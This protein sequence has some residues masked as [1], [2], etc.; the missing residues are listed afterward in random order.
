MLVRRL[1]EV[2][3]ENY[4]QLLNHFPLHQA[5]QGSTE[6]VE[7]LNTILPASSSE[8]VTSTEILQYLRKGGQK[9]LNRGLRLQR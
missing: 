4:L 1:L 9:G 8:C 7:L 3:L 2:R 5:R 6:V